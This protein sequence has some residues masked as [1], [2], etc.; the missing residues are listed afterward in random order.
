MNCL[1]TIGKYEG[2]FVKPMHQEKY[3]FGTEGRLYF[4]GLDRL[5][6]FRDEGELTSLYSDT[7]GRIFLSGNTA[8]VDSTQPGSERFSPR[9]LGL[10]FIGRAITTTS[11]NASC[12]ASGCCVSASRRGGNHPWSG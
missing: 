9:P 12:G 10:S 3:I 6:H 1:Q 7:L 8:L 11:V 5:K 4:R 2:F